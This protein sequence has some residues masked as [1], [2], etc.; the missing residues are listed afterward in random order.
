MAETTPKAAKKPAASKAEPKAAAKAPPAVLSVSPATTIAAT[1]HRP[2]QLA[3]LID[4]LLIRQRPPERAPG[5]WGK[6]P[7]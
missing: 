7:V 3:P 2:T 4:T 6:T 5:P 1:N